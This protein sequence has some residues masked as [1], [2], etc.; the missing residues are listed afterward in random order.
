[1]ESTKILYELLKLA[2]KILTDDL[3][4]LMLEIKKKTSAGLITFMMS[5][6]EELGEN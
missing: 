4:Y 2:V 6:R 3:E 5:F 1:M